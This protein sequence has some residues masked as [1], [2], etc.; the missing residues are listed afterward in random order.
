[1]VIDGAIYG[2]LR[3]ATGLS[4]RRI[5]KLLARRD[6]RL[7]KMIKS[8]VRPV[9]KLFTTLPLIGEPKEIIEFIEEYGLMPADALIALTCKQHE[10]NTIATLDEDFKR[11][12]WLSVIP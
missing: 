11:I 10:L 12:P 4:A 9:L 3:L 1:L 2:Y 7:I 8:E 5:R 6:E